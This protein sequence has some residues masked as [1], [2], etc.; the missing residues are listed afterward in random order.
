MLHHLIPDPQYG[1]LL[2]RKQALTTFQTTDHHLRKCYPSLTE[3]HHLIRMQGPDHVIRV[4]FTLDGLLAIADLLNT[5]QAQTIKATILQATQS[6]Q[7]NQTNHPSHPTPGALI[8]TH[9][10]LPDHTPHIPSALT[11]PFPTTL[12]PISQFQNH[13]TETFG[14]HPVEPPPSQNP[15]VPDPRI[16]LV[17]QHLQ[18]PLTQSVQTAIQNAIHS[19]PPKTPIP[20]PTHTC[21]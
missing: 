18:T 1:L 19:T 7:L 11:H 8:P 6:A 10:T 14:N 5:P 3:G 15:T 2:P 4:F 12:T 20:K 16:A 21:W 13:S 17:A 9:P